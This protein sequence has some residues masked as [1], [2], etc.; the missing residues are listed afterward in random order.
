[1]SH[2]HS[3]AFIN[4]QRYMWIASNICVVVKYFIMV[5]LMKFITRNDVTTIQMSKN[6]GY[7]YITLEEYFNSLNSKPFKTL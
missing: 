2:N 7:E 1:M 3:C 6:A 4:M 5:T